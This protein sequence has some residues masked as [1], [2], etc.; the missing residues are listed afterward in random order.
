M[1]LNK[2]IQ[3]SVKLC[4]N[5]GLFYNFYDSNKYYCAFHRQFG[6]YQYHSNTQITQCKYTN[7]T[8]EKFITCINKKYYNNKLSLYSE[9]CYYHYLI[10]ISKKYVILNTITDINL[11]KQN[12]KYR[13]EKLKLKK[14]KKNYDR[15]EYKLNF[16]L[17]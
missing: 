11:K 6:M 1:T 2:I 14:S 8:R 4:N 12:R 7:N 5:E 13:I 16:I 10:K 17:N 3:C 9:Y 15:I